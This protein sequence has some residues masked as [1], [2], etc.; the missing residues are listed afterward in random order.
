MWL[1]LPANKQ[2]ELTDWGLKATEVKDR[3]AIRENG[4]LGWIYVPSTQDGYKA[5]EEKADACEVWI[6]DPRGRSNQPSALPESL[7]GK[8]TAVFVHFG[9]RNRMDWNPQWIKDEWKKTLR[10][11]HLPDHLVNVDVLP[12]SMG[13]D[14]EGQADLINFRKRHSLNPEHLAL[15][16]KK[17]WSAIYGEVAAINETGDLIRALFPLYLDAA[18]HLEQ[19]RNSTSAPESAD[20]TG[21]CLRCLEEF[22]TLYKRLSEEYTK[23][24]PQIAQSE[25]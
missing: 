2:N 20:L 17:T 18:H 15:A 13:S 10:D 7:A 23:S 6:L 1:I 9:S 16:W 25:K 12:M 8:I 4:E 19:L 5:L 22:S 3:C 24:A 14:W 21:K 11:L